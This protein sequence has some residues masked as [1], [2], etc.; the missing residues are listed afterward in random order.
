MGPSASGGLSAALAL[1]V[2]DEGGPRLLGQLLI[3][4]MLDDRN[5][6]ASAMR[7]DG[8]EFWNRRYNLFGWTSLFCAF[9]G[10]ADVPQYRQPDGPERG[11]HLARRC[12]A[13]V[14]AAQTGEYGTGPSPIG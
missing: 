12:T 6:S 11:G 3:A 1:T 13:A 4:P 14:A 7:M 8:I 10:G 5:D 9:Q 2:R